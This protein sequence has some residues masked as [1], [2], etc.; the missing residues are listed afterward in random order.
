MNTA[1]DR[2]YY[3]LDLYIYLL[4]ACTDLIEEKRKPPGRLQ[5]R[6]AVFYV[7]KRKNRRSYWIPAKMLR[8]H[9]DCRDLNLMGAERLLQRLVMM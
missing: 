6:D 3:M 7:W 9:V 2:F 8:Q 4:S 1:L 5:C